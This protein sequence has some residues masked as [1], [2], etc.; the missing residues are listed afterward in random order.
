MDTLSKLKEERKAAKAASAQKAKEVKTYSKRVARLQARAA[1][2]S[3][4][5]LLVEY[6]RR[7]AAKERKKA[8]VLHRPQSLMR[9][10]CDSALYI[11][12]EEK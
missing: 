1:K 3:D 8:A 5:G 11:V 12:E 4:D 6:A 7:Q 2:L 9:S 10:I